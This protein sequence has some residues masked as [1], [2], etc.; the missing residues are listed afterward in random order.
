MGEL[1]STAQSTLHGVLDRFDPL[2]AALYWF[3][4]ANEGHI[5]F[6]TKRQL[7]EMMN[8]REKTLYK[9]LADPERLRPIELELQ[10]HNLTLKLD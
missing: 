10:R 6:D 2:Q 4:V 1:S 3:L 7:A 8:V 5:E 9:L